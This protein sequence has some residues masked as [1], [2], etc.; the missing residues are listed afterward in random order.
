MYDK[1][2]QS[3]TPKTAADE[4]TITKGERYELIALIAQRYNEFKEAP[5]MEERHI[6][7]SNDTDVDFGNIIGYYN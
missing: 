5:D 1:K 2:L 4:F 7:D 3:V 6:W